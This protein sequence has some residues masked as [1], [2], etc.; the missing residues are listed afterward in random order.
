M[1]AKTVSLELDARLAH[2]LA[3]AIRAYALAAYPRGGSDCA[4]VAREA[5]L[6][7][8]DTCAA[9]AAGPLV[10]RK[11]IMPQLR[12]AVRWC[13]SQD[14]PPNVE[15]PPAVESILAANSKNTR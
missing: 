12:A 1:K 8:A 4:Q 2:S 10:L 3:E 5:L 14:G 13:L 11:R 15:L 7:T 6:D 9:H